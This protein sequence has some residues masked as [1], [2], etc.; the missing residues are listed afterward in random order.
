[1]FIEFFD[2]FCNCLSS[3]IDIMK[4]FVLFE[5]FTFWNLV[6]ALMAIPIIFKFI[7]F[8]MAIEDEE[9]HFEQPIT[10]N[11]IRQYDRHKSKKRG[12][13]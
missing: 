4:T 6:V 9:V 5:G 7:H 12:W 11:Y 10:S 2:W 3:V 8:I 13:F 1:M